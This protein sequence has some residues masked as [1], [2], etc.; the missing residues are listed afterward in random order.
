[1]APDCGVELVSDHVASATGWNADDFMREPNL[2]FELI[3]PDDVQAVRQSTDRM[4]CGGGPVMRTYRLRH[5]T[6]RWRWFEDRVAPIVDCSGR[7]IGFC[8]AARDVTDAREAQAHAILTDRLSAL[9]M[10]AASVAHELNSP[11]T[12]L[13]LALE[14]LERKFE[15]DAARGSVPPA[16]RD[17]SAPTP[18]GADSMALLA[19]ARD[20]AARMKTIAADLC[21]FSRDA[22][23]R[24]NVDPR[25]SVEQALRLVGHALERISIVRRF[26][27]VPRVLANEARLTQVFVNLLL[28]AAHASTSS[29]A[30][31]GEIRVVTTTESDCAVIEVQDDGIGI[32]PGALP[33]IFE[34]FYTSKP[35]GLG[36]GLGLFISRKIVSDLG[37]TLE[38]QSTVN[39]GTTFRVLLPSV[40]QDK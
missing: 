6:G 29:G 36:T 26:G 7:R 39:V 4:L 12:S 38:V 5:H 31:L 18:L 2:W 19:A 22:E 10:L 9:G 16:G 3:H 8:G 20:A 34:P 17:A 21:G 23:S 27:A 33:H 40:T 13:Q 37:G 30:P 14:T 15:S 24:A 1:M 35:V 25:E 11:L 28:N 32:P